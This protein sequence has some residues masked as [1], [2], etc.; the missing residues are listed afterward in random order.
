MN[1]LQITEYKNI[2]VLTTQ[3]IAEAYGSD[4]RVI[5]NN[6][7][8]NK[9][10]YVVGKHYICLEDGEKRDFI[11]R[12]QFDDG[13]KKASK[14][15][16]WTEKGAFLHAKSL[17]TDTAWNVY[18]RLVDSYFNNQKT[19][20]LS[21]LSPEL[22][23]FNR[24]F[25]SVAE[26][27]LE[28][29][30]QAEKIAEVESRVDSIRDVV[31]LD[32]TSWRDD[33]GKILKKIGFSLGGGQTDSQVRNESYELLQKRFGV[34]LGQRLTNK[35]RRMADEGVSKSRRDKL[36]YIDIIADD[37]KLIEGYTAIVKEMAI[38]YGVA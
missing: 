30:R 11:D 8:R 21:Q 12:H 14:L 17:N 38:H 22:Q 37:K 33:T 25:Q 2:R 1:K 24:I 32:T 9:D 26:Q 20:D 36:S 23:M 27:Q 35:R 34:N 4:T 18:D 3:Q 29:K 15:Y 6:F 28:Q 16:L 10:R 31:S 7:N 13:S 5:S 19:I